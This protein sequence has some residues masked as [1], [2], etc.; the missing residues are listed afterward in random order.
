MAQVYLLARR[1]EVQNGSVMVTDLFPNESQRNTSIDPVGAGPIYIRQVDLGAQGSLRSVLKTDSAGVI[2]FV[3]Q[4]SGLIAFLLKNV[5]S[6]ANNDA[7]TLGEATVGAKAILALVRS[8]AVLNLAAINGILD[9]ATVGGAGTDLSTHSSVS[10]LLRVLAG[11]TYLVPA[12]S[13]IE[14]ANNVFTPDLN[15]S[16]YFQN[17]V[18]HPVDGDSSWLV[19]LEEGSLKGLSSVQNPEVGFA[20]V[21]T[22]TPIVTVYN[23]DGTLV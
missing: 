13:Q 9:D 11:E 17:D 23:A 8:G 16:S 20:G 2:T 21:K 7:L 4:A 5:Q 19:S 12:N 6:G 22:S 1:A 3:N 18:R 15:A 14:G 10:E